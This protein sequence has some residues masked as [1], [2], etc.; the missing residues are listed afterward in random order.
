MEVIITGDYHQKCIKA[1]YGTVLASSLEYRLD[2][3][4][5]LAKKSVELSITVPGVQ[6][7]ISLGFIK[8]VL[9]NEYRVRLTIMNALNGTY[10]LKPQN[11]LHKE[12]PE[13]ELLS[14]KLA[15]LFKINT[16]LSNMIRLQSGEL[17]FI[18]KR[19]D[20]KKDSTKIHMIDFLQIIE[21]ENKYMAQ[22]NCL[23]K[24]LENYL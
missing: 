12:I 6:P 13:N 11:I 8:T 9:K 21:L 20:R 23:V 18:T 4:E 10:I 24:P 19:I 16:V 17:C 3:M 2:K 22:W 14:I 1:F 15:G 7:M 5:K